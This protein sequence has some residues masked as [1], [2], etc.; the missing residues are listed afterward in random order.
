MIM[1]G[2]K[3]TQANISKKRGIFITVEFLVPVVPPPIVPVPMRHRIHWRLFGVAQHYVRV[4]ALSSLLYC[5]APKAGFVTLL[6]R[7]PPRTPARPGTPASSLTT[8]QSPVVGP[9]GLEQ[10][11][12][13]PQLPPRRRC[14]RVFRAKQSGGAVSP[15]PTAPRSSSPRVRLVL[16][17]RS[18]LRRRGPA[19][20]C[21]PQQFPHA[22]LHPC[23]QEHATSKL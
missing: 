23:W 3:T 17:I 11:P 18:I 6:L 19:L 2:N 9:T 13:L 12:G 16:L 7:K 14:E 8:F 10:P 20:N 4:R 22:A 21:I 1:P 15:A 5:V